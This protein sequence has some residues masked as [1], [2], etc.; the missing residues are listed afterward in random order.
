MRETPSESARGR[1][2]SGPPRHEVGG[3][4]P[5]RYRR[6][7]T[8]GTT[9]QRRRLLLDQEPSGAVRALCSPRAGSDAVLNHQD[10]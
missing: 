6:G 7:M 10:G 1:D 4:Y 2:D 3:R 9:F 8:T 5:Y